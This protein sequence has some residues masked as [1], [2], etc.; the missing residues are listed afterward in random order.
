MLKRRGSA[1]LGLQVDWQFEFVGHGKVLSSRPDTVALDV[2]NRL[3]PGVLDQHHDRDLAPSTSR[4]ILEHPDLAYD[5]LMSPWLRRA[6]DGVAL[7]GK[8]WSPIITTHWSSDLDAV[9]SA[10]LVQE[11]VK[12]G[13]LPDWA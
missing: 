11:L 4:L 3:E 7:E 9:V 2:G 13:T 12:N 1:D 6:D 8:V 5:H 10:L